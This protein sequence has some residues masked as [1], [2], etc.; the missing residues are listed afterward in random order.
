MRP[1]G[2]GG[3]W[4]ITREKAGDEVKHR[5]EISKKQYNEVSSEKKVG[6]SASILTRVESCA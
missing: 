4:G 3:R 6:L 2:G 1:G 5:V